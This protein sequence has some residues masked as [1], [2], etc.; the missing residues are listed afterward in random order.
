MKRVVITGLGIISSIGNKKEEVLHSLKEGNSGI[1]FSNEFKKAGLRS[2]ICGD[3]KLSENYIKENI[4]RKFLRFMSDC[5][6]YA[7]LSMKEAIQD[8]Q[9][10]EQEVSNCNTGLI[11]GSGGGSPR[12]QVFGS[13]CM[14]KRGIRS[15]GPYMVTKAMASGISACLATSFGIKGLSYSVSSACA[16][17]AHCI[18][19]GFELIQSNKQNVIFAGGGEEVTWELS[20]EFDA[21][22][23]LSTKY[24]HTPKKASR[25]YD[26]D[27]DGFVISGGAGIIVMEELEH[28]LKRK[29][30][31]YSE[32]IGYGVSSDGY[33]M[34]VPSGEGAVRCMNMALKNVNGKIDYIN[35]HG[36]STKIGDTKELDAIKIVFNKDIPAI[37]ST[38]SMT[39]HA[40]GAAGVHEIIYTLLM[41][42]NNFIAPSIN[43]YNLDKNAEKMNI[44]TKKTKKILKIAMSNSFGFGGTNASLVIKKYNI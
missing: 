18:G 12:N 33:D 4:K 30:H 24:N 44:I 5:S 19:H 7:Y 15:I 9:L 14:R 39:G 32:I 17:S 3:I 21:M 42:N 2:C 38:K 29:A 36:T 37:S 13:D 31:I 20:C 27:R 41:L 34:V 26:Q 35:T 28:A 23:A 10:T 22:G 6:I 1:N 8:S 16:T 40:L 43:I 25:T 11:V